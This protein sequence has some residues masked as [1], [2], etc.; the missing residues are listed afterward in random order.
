[1]RCLKPNGQQRPRTFDPVFVRGRLRAAGTQAALAF[2]RQLARS[3][4][5]SSLG[6]AA[7]SP[8]PYTETEA[9]A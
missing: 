6:H 7:S 9:D 2:A 8:P 1:M 5:V 3:G 4:E